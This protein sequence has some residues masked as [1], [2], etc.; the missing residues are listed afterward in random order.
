MADLEKFVNIMEN[1]CGDD[2]H[3][4]SQYHR[5]GPDY[6]CSSAVIYALEQAGWPMNG[7]LTTD[8]IRAPLVAQGWA[9]LPPSIPKERGDILLAEEYHVA[10]YVGG[11]LLAEFAIDEAGGIAG[12]QQGD[13]TGTEA[14]IHEYYDYPWDGVLRYTGQEGKEPKMFCII[15]PYGQN[16]KVY[17]DGQKIHPLGHPDQVEVLQQI[18]ER[19]NGHRMPEFELGA[20]DAPWFTRLVEAVSN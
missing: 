9:W 7:A 3:G 17:F 13:Q 10:V 6:D 1:L 19:C 2:T 18:H 16:Y 8:H 11:G 14:Y 20:A 15:K 12:N 4:Y 5:Y